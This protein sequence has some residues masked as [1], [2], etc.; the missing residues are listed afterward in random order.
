MTVIF[1]S[2]FI[3]D[4]PAL[5]LAGFLLPASVSFVLK[6]F[7]HFNL[8]FFLL[9]RILLLKLSIF[10]KGEFAKIKQ[11]RIRCLIFNPLPDDK[12]LDWSK[13]KQIED[14]VLKCI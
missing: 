8:D 7:I 1:L 12:L 14:D 3:K 10:R 6:E 13:L 2:Y 5:E 4:L 11:H 9:I